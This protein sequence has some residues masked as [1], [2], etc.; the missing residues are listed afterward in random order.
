MDNIV[1]ERDYEQEHK[2]QSKE[3]TASAIFDIAVD[4][5]FL[6]EYAKAMETIP[7]V[8]VPADKANYEYLLERADELAKRWGGRVRGVVDYKKWD[9]SIDLILPFAEFG[10]RDD[11][12][13][14][15]E[16]ADKSHS[17]TF[18]A[19]E[20][21]KLR[22]YVWFFYF[23]EI[24]DKQEILESMIKSNP[25]LTSLIEKYYDENPSLSESDDEVD[26]LDDSE[27]VE[28]M[29]WFVETWVA[30]TGESKESVASV[31]FSEMRRDYR[32]MLK[33]MLELKHTLEEGTE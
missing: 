17:L 30:A 14:L 11:R 6:S 33:K 5:G 28:L 7:K 4:G 15:M 23:E 3:D 32:G 16:F 13:L 9:A 8:V 26:S 10:S 31:I 24:A 29:T 21:G 22:I 12:N 1:F 20:D 25:E 18:Q 2:Q 27:Q 19:T